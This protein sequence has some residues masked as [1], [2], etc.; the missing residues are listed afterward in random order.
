[1]QDHN[2]AQLDLIWNDCIQIYPRPHQPED[3]NKVVVKLTIGPKMQAF[4]ADQT[5]S[6]NPFY[7]AESV[8]MLD[9]YTQFF[10]S[11]ETLKIVYPDLWDLITIEWVDEYGEAQTRQVTKIDV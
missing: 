1:M 8:L 10:G 5:G 4:I 7:D 9:V 6:D 3:P 11:P 2:G